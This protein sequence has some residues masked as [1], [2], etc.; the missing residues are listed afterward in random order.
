MVTTYALMWN[1]NGIVQTMEYPTAG[2][3]MDQVRGIAIKR[4]RKYK[5]A[6]YIR[7]TGAHNSSGYVFVTDGDPYWYSYKK[8]MAYNLLESGRIGGW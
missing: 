1:H 6:I 5:K 8:K 7:P 2:L 3:S 4:A